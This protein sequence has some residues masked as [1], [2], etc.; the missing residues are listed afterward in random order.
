MK[1]LEAKPNLEHFERTVNSTFENFRTA[2]NYPLE[3]H[4]AKVLECHLKDKYHPFK[5]LISRYLNAQ[6]LFVMASLLIVEAEKLPKDAEGEKKY[7]LDHA[8]QFLTQAILILKEQNL[9][10]TW[11]YKHCLYALT[12]INAMEGVL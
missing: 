2:P 8:E 3:Y 9:T 5:E 7:H 12:K 6:K 11:L 4:Y 1:V 10:Y